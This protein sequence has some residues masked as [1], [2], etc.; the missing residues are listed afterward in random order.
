MKYGFIIPDGDTKSIPEFAVEA[1]AAGWDGV[2]I[3]DCISI[4]KDAYSAGAAANRELK[5]TCYQSPMQQAEYQKTT[6]RRL[7]RIVHR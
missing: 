3:P 7:V 4:E 2:F 5:D 6:I 1:E